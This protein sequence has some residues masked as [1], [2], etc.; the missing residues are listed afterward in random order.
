MYRLMI[1]ILLSSFC[2]RFIGL[3][4][5]VPSKKHFIYSI[6]A[7]RVDNAVR[8]P[9]E[10]LGPD[11]SVTVDYKESGYYLVRIELLWLEMPLLQ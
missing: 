9:F 3:C 6:A 7:Y 10:Q 5:V 8:P 2:M 1:L 11:V 4:R